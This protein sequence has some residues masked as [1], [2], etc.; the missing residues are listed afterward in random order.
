MTIRHT[1]LPVNPLSWPGGAHV[2]SFAMCAMQNGRVPAQHDNNGIGLSR[3]SRASGFGR[4]G[5]WAGSGWAF[6]DRTHAKQRHV[7]ATREN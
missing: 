6:I 2:A 4:S 1:R 5:H 7:C 3:R